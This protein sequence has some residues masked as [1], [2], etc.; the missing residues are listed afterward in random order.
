MWGG[1]SSTVGRRPFLY[2]TTERVHNN[3]PRKEAIRGRASKEM[4]A[5]TDIDVKQKS[6]RE[7]GH[8]TPHS[9][10]R[11]PKTKNKK[12]HERRTGGATKRGRAREPKAGYARGAARDGRRAGPFRPEGAGAVAKRPRRARSQ[13]YIR[14]RL[15]ALEVSIT[16]KDNG[17][18]AGGTDKSHER[19]PRREPAAR[20]PFK[21]EGPGQQRGAAADGRA[22]ATAADEEYSR[23]VGH[24]EATK[25]RP[26]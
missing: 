22:L 7:S 11:E 9:G 4:I 23:R 18:H 2:P 16:A 17:Q 3:L 6:G 26:P 20:R 1:A 19:E 5:R 15:R 12:S 21:A 8:H 13:S 25:E 24:T 10:L 14:A